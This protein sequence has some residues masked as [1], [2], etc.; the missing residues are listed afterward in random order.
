M[1]VA[2]AS[3]IYLVLYIGQ[4]SRNTLKNVM[5]DL[6]QISLRNASKFTN[7]YKMASNIELK[8]RFEVQTLK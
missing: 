5:Q 4:Q 8:L 1:H 2:F 6:R 3:I 7:N